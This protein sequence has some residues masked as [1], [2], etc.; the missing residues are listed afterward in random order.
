MDIDKIIEKIEDQHPYK[1]AG[2]RDSYSEYNEGWSDA[3]DI[4][5]SEIER[6]EGRKLNAP[7]NWI[8]FVVVQR[9]LG[10]PFFLAL[11][12]F[13]VIILFIKYMANYIKYGGE[14]ISYTEKTRRKMIDDVFHKL[15]EQQK[16]K[17]QYGC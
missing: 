7:S 9:I 14:A 5:K 17:E 12:T 1:K 6:R 16:L 10:F 13:G 11:A 4:I 15:V 2:D 8:I 3:C